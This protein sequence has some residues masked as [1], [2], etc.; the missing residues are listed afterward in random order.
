MV[1]RTRGIRTQNINA[2]ERA[3]AHPLNLSVDNH[4]L[5]QLG[6]GNVASTARPFAV[7]NR[8]HWIAIQSGAAQLN[9]PRPATSKVIGIELHRESE[10]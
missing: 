8:P 7:G 1:S 3:E 10:K 4:R 5:P 6:D 9:P 2:T